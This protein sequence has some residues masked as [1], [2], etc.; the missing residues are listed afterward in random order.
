MW[1]R[2]GI[3]EVTHTTTD[4]HIVNVHFTPCCI[5]ICAGDRFC[6]CTSTL[7]CEA[8]GGRLPNA[9]S[10]V[11]DVLQL[12]GLP[13]EISLPASLYSHQ[14]ASM[15]T[16]YVASPIIASR[17]RIPTA[18]SPMSKSRACRQLFRMSEEER[19]ELGNVPDSVQEELESMQ[20][21]KSRRWSFDFRTGIPLPGSSWERVAAEDVPRFYS[22]RSASVQ[23][24]S[25][26]R[27]M[28]RSHG[29]L[30]SARTSES[31][32]RHHSVDSDSST[33][34]KSSGLPRET[35]TAHAIDNSAPREHE[36]APS[37][38][39]RVQPPLDMLD[40]INNTDAPS[41][42]QELRPVQRH[43]TGKHRIFLTSYFSR[44]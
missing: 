12:R 36:T 43:I 23:S 6:R 4:K 15:S 44:Q 10:S 21:E 16:V 2:L 39:E 7:T 27:H 30:S 28:R 31:P 8:Y 19:Q 32:D 24:R 40:N 17:G 13:V 3:G 42:S 25:P 35:V 18:V 5:F 9:L 37:L 41:S 33:S 22:P 11:S 38:H 34:S 1:E 26:R 20:D 14:L 29:L